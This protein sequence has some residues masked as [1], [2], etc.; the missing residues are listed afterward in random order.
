MRDRADAAREHLPATVR[1]RVEIVELASLVGAGSAP[2]QENESAGWALEG[3]AAVLDATCRAAN[4]PLVGRVEGG[5]FLLDFRCLEG[6]DAAEAA[7]IVGEALAALD[8][9]ETAG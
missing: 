4:P 7:R 1:D 9:A 6:D 8:G 5:R 2:E 3:S